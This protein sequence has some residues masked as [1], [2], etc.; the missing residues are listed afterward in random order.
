MQP[1][2]IFFQHCCYHGPDI[3]VLFV[4]GEWVQSAERADARQL[5]WKA[6]TDRSGEVFV[7]VETNCFKVQST[8]SLYVLSY[9]SW[10]RSKCSCKLRTEVINE[11]AM[12]K[13]L[14][15]LDISVS[16]SIRLSLACKTR[17]LR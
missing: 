14:R 4:L 15:V 11:L 9:P 10:S 2:V 5:S 3:A 12:S 1:T 17:V 6:S 8:P 7:L 16:V 13:H